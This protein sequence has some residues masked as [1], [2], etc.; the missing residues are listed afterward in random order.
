MKRYPA[1]RSA[2]KEGMS[3]SDSMLSLFAHATKVNIP[4]SAPVE[5]TGFF[6]ENGSWKEKS[7]AYLY[8]SPAVGVTGLS[9]D[10][11]LVRDNVPTLAL[12]YAWTG[13]ESAATLFTAKTALD[14]A[15]QARGSKPAA[16]RLF[17]YERYPEISSP[18]IFELQTTVPR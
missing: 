16:Y 13:E 18:K 7:V 10:T 11:V 15:A 9:D 3:R 4:L 2:V 12:S 5:V 17:V 8:P 14:T 1:Y 6:D